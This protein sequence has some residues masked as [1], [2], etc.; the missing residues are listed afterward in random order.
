M[1]GGSQTNEMGENQRRQ[2][3]CTVKRTHIIYKVIRIKETLHVNIITLKS[4]YCF[5]SS[6]TNVEIVL[7]QVVIGLKFNVSVKD[8]WI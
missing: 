3:C 4:I 8:D 6:M 5:L 1:W 7:K 2:K